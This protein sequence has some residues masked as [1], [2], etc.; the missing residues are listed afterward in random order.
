MARSNPSMTLSVRISLEV[1]DQLR[2][3]CKATGRTKSFLAA[4]AIETYLT[5]QAWQ[6]EAIKS[7]IKKADSKNA[8]FIEHNKVAEWLK[9]WG[10][11]DEKEIPK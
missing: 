6:V 3:L 10:D 4:E 5:T 1:C 8:K 11:E 7:A 9:S 2:E